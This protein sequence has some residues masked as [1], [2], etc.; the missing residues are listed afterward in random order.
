[1]VIYIESEKNESEQF[2]AVSS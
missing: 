1:M 2:E